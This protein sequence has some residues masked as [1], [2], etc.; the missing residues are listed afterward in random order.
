MP[1]VSRLVPVVLSFLVLGAHFL[2]AGNVS[3]VGLVFLLLALLIVRRP[4]AARAVQVALVLGCLEW[5]RT[6]IH[7]SGERVQAGQ[8]VLRL[9]IILGI[10]AAVTLLSALAFQGGR[11][12]RVYG[13]RKTDG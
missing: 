4:W 2:R 6:L 1:V 13:L 10:V 9:V 3:L 12:S 11:L 8:P 7:L 5:V